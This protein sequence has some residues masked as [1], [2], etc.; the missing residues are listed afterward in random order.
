MRNERGPVAHGR[1]GFLDAVS[2]DHARAFLHVGDAI[3]GVLLSALE[4]KQ[5]DPRV[6]REPYEN[7]PHLNTRIDRAVNMEVQIDEDNDRPVAIFSLETRSP[8]GAIELHVEPSRLLYGI[9]REAYVEVL[10]TTEL[11]VAEDEVDADDTERKETV[12]EPVVFTADKTAVE[13]KRVMTLVP[14]YSGTLNRIRADL[15][16]FLIAEEVKLAEASDGSDQL[17]DSL[18]ATAEQNIR[19]DWKTRT[20]IQAGLKIACKRVFI[21]F[22][23]APQKADK[24]AKAM[25]DWLREQ[26]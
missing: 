23:F 2:A 8:D 9:D 3:L 13:A 16:A 5:P 25:I 10:R 4:G 7:F 26:V 17:V 21:R 6:T 11:V 20:Q 18:L 19:L 12:P 15:E 14:I 22:G 1:D 24:V